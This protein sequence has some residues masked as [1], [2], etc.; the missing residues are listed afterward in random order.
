[1]GTWSDLPRRLATVSIGAP[2]IVSLLSHPITSQLFFHCVHLLCTIEWM[3]LV[4]REKQ[5]QKYRSSKND[6]S[7][8]SS[9]QCHHYYYLKY[10]FP[11][12]SLLIS[13]LPKD[14]MTTCMCLGASLLFLNYQLHID[15]KKDSS[16]SKSSN[17]PKQE[18]VIPASKTTNNSNNQSITHTTTNTNTNTLEEQKQ[19]RQDGIQQHCIHGFIFL[20]IPFHHWLTLSKLS[21][22][23]I[24]YPLFIIWNGD[25]G[26]LLAGRLG[27]TFIGRFSTP[28]AST[29]V[30]ISCNCQSRIG[31][32]AQ[33][34]KALEKDKAIEDEKQK[35]ESMSSLLMQRIHT[36]SPAKSMNGFVG[37]IC[38]S[39][40]TAIY[41]PSFLVYLGKKQKKIFASFSSSSPTWKSSYHQLDQIDSGDRILDFDFL[42]KPAHF[43][44]KC[45][46]IL[47]MKY[48][49]DNITEEYIEDGN[50]DRNGRVMIQ[51]AIVGLL[52]GLTA[53]IGDLVESAVKRNASVKDSGKLLPG[54][55]GI[56]DRFDSTFLSVGLYL[57]LVLASSS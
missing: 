31:T 23:H 43:V 25:T 2:L 37:C 44:F 18:L 14:Y 8:H 35:E 27:K 4:P 50:Y 11:L 55:G 28:S 48:D 16:F 39:I 42:H 40:L 19:Q 52:L 53:I 46:G 56:L 9:R 41:M 24:V 10:V 20:T 57:S 12:L 32:G 30:N 38:F 7:S 17:N 34:D 3:R 29:T 47:H 21:F 22:V 6:S 5:S 45:L 33:N 49:Y 54:H 15:E 51:R 1:M 26:A 36:I 13:S